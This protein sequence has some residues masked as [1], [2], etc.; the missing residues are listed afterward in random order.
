MAYTPLGDVNGAPP[1]FWVAGEVTDFWLEIGHIGVV[2]QGSVP[3]TS[4]AD[5]PIKK[6]ILA[7][8]PLFDGNLGLGGVAGRKVRITF[9]DDP[10]FP[11][12]QLL[13]ATTDSTKDTYDYRLPQPCCRSTCRYSTSRTVARYDLASG[14]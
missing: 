7:L 13:S 8:G 1:P 12:G 6:L 3:P 10:A 2:V 14:K 11:S 9:D 4:I 5:P